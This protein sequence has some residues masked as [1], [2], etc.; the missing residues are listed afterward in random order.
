[1]RL[2]LKQKEGKKLEINLKPHTTPTQLNSQP[3]SMGC[4]CSPGAKRQTL[5]HQLE[6]GKWL[7]LSASQSPS[8]KQEQYRIFFSYARRFNKGSICVP[9]HH[10]EFDHGPVTPAWPVYT[11][12]GPAFCPLMTLTFLRHSWN[13]SQQVSSSVSYLSS[14]SYFR[15]NWLTRDTYITQSFSPRSLPGLQVCTSGQQSRG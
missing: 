11:G 3:S 1:M 12:S 4:S 6:M 7:D 5:N 2:C 8:E 15:G 9:W 10:R 13:P 14:V